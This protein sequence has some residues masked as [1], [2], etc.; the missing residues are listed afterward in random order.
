MNTTLDQWE[1]LEA[2]V[3]L[4][5][6]AAAA[7]MMN[8]SQ[9]TISYAISHLQE[10]FKVPLLE[11]KGRKAYLTEAGKA[12]LADVE[13]LLTGFRALERRAASLATGGDSQIRLSVDSLYP[14]E[15]LFTAVTELTRAYPHVLPQVH[16]GPFLSSTHEFTTFGADLCVSGLTA[17]EHFVKPILDI[18][19]RAVARPDHPLHTGTRQLTRT[20]LTQRLAVIIEGTAGPEPM[21]QPHASSQRF[22][23]VN[24]I[25]S[26]IEA[27]RSGMCF[28]WLPAYRIEPLLQS[29]E[30]LPLRMA[31]GGERIARLYL[32]VKDVDSLSQEKKYIS[33]LLGANRELE[34][35]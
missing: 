30:L 5:S 10:Q 8:R 24:T 31:I 18:R 1:V 9:S 19:I 2:V 13:P 21:R 29:G 12:L 4:G 33:D 23:A 6:F 3:Q 11:M 7:S 20:D 16:K 14:N 27:V 22:M 17:R 35:I 25:E 26:A 15:R 28:G 34:V 32:V